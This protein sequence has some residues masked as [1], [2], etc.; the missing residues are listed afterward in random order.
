MFLILIWSE[1]HTS[2]ELC[3]LSRNIIYELSLNF[4]KSI[5][6]IF[7]LIYNLEYIMRKNYG[8]KNWKK[9][10]TINCQ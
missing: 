9:C 2:Y 7:D 1:L 6:K 10:K 3:S 5:E 8:E 4:N